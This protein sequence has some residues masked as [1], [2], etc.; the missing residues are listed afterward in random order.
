[1]CS[2]ISRHNIN[3]H[4]KSAK[5]KREQFLKTLQRSYSAARK[6]SQR[7]AVKLKIELRSILFARRHLKDSQTKINKLLWSD[8][9]KIEVFGVNARPHVWRIIRLMPSPPPET[10]LRRTCSR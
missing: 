10:S 7:F 8:E 1:M 5:K 6:Y 3:L 9:T 4:L 2:G